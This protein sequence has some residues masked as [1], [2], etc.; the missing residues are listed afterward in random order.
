[1]KFPNPEEKGALD[2]AIATADRR[3][4]TLILASDPDAD[5]FAAAERLPSGGWHIFTGNQLGVLFA[6]HIFGKRKSEGENIETLAMLTSTVSTQMLQAMASAEGFHY[7]ETL[8]GFK[9]LGNQA[10]VLEERGYD[11]A[12]A[13]EE[14]IGYM[15]S[16]VVHDK[17]GIAAASIFATMARQLA[18]EGF[19]VYQKLDQL[20]RKYGYFETANSY[21]VSPDPTSIKIAFAG[22]RG[23]GSPHPKKLGNRHIT[24]WRDLTEGFDSATEGGV[25]VLPVSKDSEMIT[26]EL[27]DNIRFTVR[28]SGT[29]PKIKSK[30]RY[31]HIHISA[32]SHT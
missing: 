17:D 29:E 16:P 19:T 3:N 1:M 13:F 12:Y 18:Q 11:A 26:C 8:T 15:F 2:L 24:R 23:L 25:P 7:E 20:F 9:W 21:F 10:L 31:H 27:E 6:A 5:R 4:L 30:T 22:I 28:A 14:A 32:A